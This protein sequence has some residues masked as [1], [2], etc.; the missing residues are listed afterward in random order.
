[1]S[2]SSGFSISVVIP[3]YNCEAYVAEAIESALKQ[4]Y[5]PLEII[6]VDD[7][8][9]DRTSAI[10]QAFPTPVRFASQPHGGAGAARNRGAAL[11][12]GDLLAFLDADDRW[13]R[14][15]LE[16]QVAALRPE[17]HMVF[18]RVRQLRTGKEW[19]QGIALD[20]LDGSESMNG[21][22][23]GTMLIRRGA[24]YRVGEFRSEW[25]LGEFIDWYARAVE[26]GLRS[27]CL[28]DLLLWRRIHTSNTGVL[29]HA[30]RSDYAKV[31]KAALDRR[32]AKAGHDV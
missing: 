8:S 19:E 10:V 28:P 24:F 27:V 6:V 15:K 9:V 12:T 16:R 23:P 11:A 25:K 22:I 30:Y 2:A 26:L 31:L 14:Y 21:L 18:G 29:Q 7:G 32:R 4:T 20:I 1:M 5:A 13:P 3:A 17:L